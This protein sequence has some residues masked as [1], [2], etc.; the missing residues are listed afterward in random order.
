MAFSITVEP[1]SASISRSFPSWSMKVIVG[2]VG[3]AG[4]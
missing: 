4:R 2:M 3:V 1:A